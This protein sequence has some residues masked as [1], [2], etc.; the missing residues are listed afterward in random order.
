MYKSSWRKTLICAFSFVIAAAPAAAGEKN[1]ADKNIALVRSMVEAIDAR[2][3]DALENIVADD[4]VR[5]SAATPGLQVTSRDQFIQFL[6]ADIAAIPDVRQ[7]IDM[8]FAAD[9][10]VALR[11]HYRGTQT[12]QMGPFPPSGQK[13]DQPFMGILRIEDGRIAEIWVEW[14]NLGILTALGHVTPPGPPAAE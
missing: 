12:G 5:H 6:K 9:D 1:S 7:D 11:A 3:F 8:I 4:L 10:L 13:V 14:D 2:N